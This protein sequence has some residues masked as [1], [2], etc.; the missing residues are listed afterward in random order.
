MKSGRNSKIQ[1]KQCQN[2]YFRL[3]YQ[4][5]RPDTAMYQTSSDYSTADLG[6]FFSSG[7]FVEVLSKEMERLKVVLRQLM[8]QLLQLE[9]STFTVL[10]P[11]SSDCTL[12]QLCGHN[13]TT[14][15][16]NS[17]CVNPPLNSYPPGNK[18]KQKSC[19]SQ[20]LE[21]QE[22]VIN[23]HE[24]NMSL[25]CKVRQT[26]SLFIELYAEQIST[27]L[28]QNQTKLLHNSF[29]LLSDTKPGTNHLWWGSQAAFER[30]ASTD[31]W[32]S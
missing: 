29:L 25:K 10:C 6:L 26:D 30:T 19:T 1:H 31:Y 8:K 2:F 27:S 14:I 17:E 5:G 18:W 22:L 16:I 24:R 23:L 3:Q 15:T 7:D 13:T 32:L 9:H 11:I 21:E 12:I 20:D 4:I 28:R